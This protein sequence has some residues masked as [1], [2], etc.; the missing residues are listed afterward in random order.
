M[1]DADFSFADEST[2]TMARRRRRVF[3]LIEANR[4]LPLVKRIAG[5]IARTHAEARRL[6]AQL[7][8]K[9]ARNE[10]QQ[11]EAELDLVVTKLQNYVDELTD[12]GAEL[13]DYQSGLIDFVSLH[14]GREVYLCW[15]LGEEQIGHWHELEAGFQG[16][17]PVSILQQG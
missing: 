16:R 5:D 1:A 6:H 3:T 9:M 8:R 15:K 12:V 11:I 13:K 10:R 4:T 17:Q 7:T 14:Q 2:I